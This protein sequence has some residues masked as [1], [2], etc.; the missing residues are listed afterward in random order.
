MQTRPDARSSKRPLSLTTRL[1]LLPD[2][3]PQLT[4]LIKHTTKEMG[5]NAPDK[6]VADLM[7]DAI[8]TR[9]SII[10]WANETLLKIASSEKEFRE[11]EEK[12]RRAA[13][14]EENLSLIHI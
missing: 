14:E 4:S 12:A 5:H 7:E 10:L 11:A 13:E 6:R 2:P 1:T 9:K 3:H 8:P